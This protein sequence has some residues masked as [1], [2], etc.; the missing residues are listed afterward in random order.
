VRLVTG[1]A[2]RRL[3]AHGDTPNHRLQ[4]AQI[5]PQGEETP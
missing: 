5:Q 2:T 3:R 1:P 4:K